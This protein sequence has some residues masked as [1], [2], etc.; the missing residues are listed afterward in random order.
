MAD[1]IVLRPDM[2][3]HFDKMDVSFLSFLDTVFQGC[4]WFTKITSDYRDPSAQSAEIMS[5]GGA[6]N[7]LH[8]IGRAVDI[9]M[10]YMGKA[11]DLYKLGAITDAICLYRHS[12]SVEFEIDITPSDAHLHLGLYPDTDKRGLKLLPTCRHS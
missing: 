6:A 2:F 3:Q 9:R 12:R 5:H 11:F 10:P 4:G 7:S 1:Y 8:E